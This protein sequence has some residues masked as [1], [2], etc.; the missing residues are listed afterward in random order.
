MTAVLASSRIPLSELHRRFTP[1]HCA[2]ATEG[3]HA[4]RSVRCQHERADLL[5]EAVLA[6]W[7]RFLALV[8]EA[9]PVDPAAI[10]QHAVAAARRTYRR[11]QHST[12]PN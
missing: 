2:I 5:S 10:A 4:F 12:L 6:A 9:T 3:R 7:E 8:T 11:A 1:V